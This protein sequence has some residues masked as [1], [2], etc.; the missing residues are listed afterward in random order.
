MT[1]LEADL[2]KCNLKK[3]PILYSN[4]TEYVQVKERR[5]GTSGADAGTLYIP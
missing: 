3:K 1:G 2:K 4:L 5:Y